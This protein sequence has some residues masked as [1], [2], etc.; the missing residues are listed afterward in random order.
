[1]KKTKPTAKHTAESYQKKSKKPY[2]N[3]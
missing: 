1:M 2:Y 3:T